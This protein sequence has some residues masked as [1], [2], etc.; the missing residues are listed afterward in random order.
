VVGINPQ[1]WNGLAAS[2]RF[3]SRYRL[4]FTNLWDSSN[5]AWRHYGGPYTSEVMLVDNQGNR[6]EQATSRFSASK[7]QRLVD[8]LD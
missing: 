3:V 6:V 5:A 1:S 4:T 8:S 2:E 7:F